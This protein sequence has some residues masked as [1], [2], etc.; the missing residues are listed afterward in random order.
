MIP[1]SGANCILFYLE[2]FSEIYSL[3]LTNL[4]QRLFDDAGPV[5]LQVQVLMSRVL[6]D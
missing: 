5:D 6:A 1:L 2:R 3:D 4:P